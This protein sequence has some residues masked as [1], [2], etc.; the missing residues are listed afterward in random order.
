MSD[1]L[2]RRATIAFRL[3]LCGLLS[4]TAAAYLLRVFNFRQ[5]SDY[6]EGT[7]LAMVQR[8]GSQRISPDW[9]RGPVYTATSYGPGYYWAVRAAAAVLPWRHGLIPGRLV[10]LAASLALAGLVGWAVRRKTG[11]VELGLLS[12]MLFL[13][14]PVVRAWATPYRVDPL[15]VLLAVSSYLLADRPRWGLPA[16]AAAIACGSLVKQTVAL[17]ALPV[18]LYLL[19]GRRY[20]AAAL[21]GLLVAAMGVL[22]WTVLNWATEGFFFATSIR[23]N[24]NAMS[25]GHGFW[26]GYEFLVTPLATAAATTLAFLLVKEPRR[27]AGS[28]YTVGFPAASLI[29]GLLA[30]K[31]GS[32]ASYFLEATALAAVVAGSEGLA[33][34]WSLHRG[35]ATIAALLLALALA[36]PEYRYIRQH[37]L[38][39]D[40]VPYGSRFIASRVEPKPGAYVL[41]DGQYLAAALD[42]GYVPL[43]NDPFFFRELSDNGGWKPDGVVGALER[44]KVEYLFMTWPIDSRREQ[45]GSKRQEWPAAV[46]AA[47]QRCYR[48]EQ[49]DEDLFVYKH[50]SR[51]SL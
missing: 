42:N 14:S 49:S 4:L 5:Q 10:S 21:F 39:L 9:L 32:S 46:L 36:A 28:I 1:P 25:L 47:M 44:G 40:R 13:A 3:A 48:L 43:M 2:S 15:A 35:R 33:F 16:A 34:F 24:L 41:A 17:T 31:E 27:W 19:V 7:V 29:A 23:G 26:S 51:K 37:G 45:V 30:C 50:R 20:R 8:M 18:F 6:G 12:A 11:S 22:A 38:R